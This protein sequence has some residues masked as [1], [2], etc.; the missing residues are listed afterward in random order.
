MKTL[1]KF[2]KDVKSCITVAGESL[3]SSPVGTSKTFAFPTT[4]GVGII[5]TDAGISCGKKIVKRRRIEKNACNALRR[6]DFKKV[7]EFGIIYREQKHGS[8][9]KMLNSCSRY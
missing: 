7:S 8:V 2:G 3:I 6:N 9:K 4:L 1:R 5:L